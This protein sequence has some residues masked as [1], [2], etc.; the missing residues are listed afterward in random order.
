MK[1][2]LFLLLLLGI[3]R[4]SVCQNHTTMGTDF[5]VSFLFFTYQ[6]TAPQYTVSLHAL[7]SAPRTCSVTMTNPT[8]TWNNTFTVA[9]GQ[10]QYIDIPF[11]SGCTELS[12]Q[13]ANTAIHVTS[14]DTISLYLVNLGQHSID[15]TNALPTESL[16]SDYMVQAYPSKLSASGRSEV[17]IVATEDS[18]IIDMHVTAPTMNGFAGGT[19]H[20]ITLNQGQAY[21]LRGWTTQEGDLTGTTISARDCKKIA[22]YSGHFCAYIPPNMSSCDHIF[23]QS[24]PT[25]YWGKRFLVTSSCSQYDDHVRVQALNSNCRVFKDGSYWRTLN[26]GQVAEFTVNSASPYSF[27]ETTEPASVYLFMGS[28]GASNGDPTMVIIN[29]IEQRVKNITFATYSTQFTNTHFLNIVADTGEMQHILLDGSPVPSTVCF[30]QYRAA[31][32]SLNQGSHTI[33]TS[34]DNGFIAYAYG[35]GLHESYG[36]SIGSSLNYMP[37]GRLYLN[38]RYVTNDSIIDVCEGRNILTVIG[39]NAVDSISWY[40]ND[41]LIGVFDTLIFDTVPGVYYIRAVVYTTSGSGCYGATAVFELGITL[42]V[43]NSYQIYAADTIVIGQLPW[44]YGYRTYT[45]A[46]SNDTLRFHTIFG[47]DSTVIYSLHVIDD[48][49]RDYFYDTICAGEPYS[50]HGFN[51]SGNTTTDIGTFRYRRSDTTYVAILYLTQL[52]IPLCHISVQI[53]GDS[54]YYLTVTTTADSFLWSSEPND[55]SLLGH[56]NNRNVVVCPREPTTY[57][58]KLFYSNHPNCPAQDKIIL[59]NRTYRQRE[60]LWIPNIF[61]PEL[62][63]NNEFKAVGVG[64]SEFEMS[65]FHRWG[66]QVFHSHDINQSWDGTR[67][68]VKCPSG[69]YVYLIYYHSIYIPNERQKRFGTVLLQR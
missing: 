64:I 3:G 34:G 22:V 69:V 14:T 48:T 23:D 10:V 37:S 11:T 46:V 49:V 59:D 30:D 68:G 27:I 2:I 54:C 33:T 66:E 12:G 13:A 1:K 42:V 51:I 63:E 35:I 36:Y 43:N 20:T 57:Y 39:S 60:T 19:D 18:T 47:C 31:R 58:L 8:T 4:V 28:S 45:G 40:I 55:L 21:Q 25:A 65:I 38:G 50:L 7:V 26:A 67:D 6:Y 61:T 29:P 41:E 53:A 5:W 52:D 24:M 32:I 44:R 62:T 15:I 16:G 17:V 56:Q 9:S